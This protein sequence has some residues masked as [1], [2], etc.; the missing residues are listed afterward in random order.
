MRTEEYKKYMELISEN[1]LDEA[2]DF[3]RDIMAKFIYK[4]YPLT[5]KTAR[6]KVDKRILNTLRNNEIWCSKLE[7]FNDPYEGIGLYFEE[8]KDTERRLADILR[9]ACFTEN[10]ATNISMWAY[11]ANCHKGF[12]VK[13][14]VLNNEKLY[15]VN[16]IEH[17]ES[18]KEIWNDALRKTMRGESSVKEQLLI[19]EKYLI[20]HVS[21]GNE[22]E[23]RIII[24]TEEKDQYGRTVKCEELGLKPVKMYTGINCSNEAKKILNTISLQLG[25]GQIAECCVSDN[26]FV[27]LK[28]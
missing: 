16:Y 12:C 13:Y 6:G 21:W 20:K 8:N 15:D 18:Q 1:K 7:C 9:V 25:C 10:A 11:Y 2:T 27:L 5:S 17:R 24:D 22:K 19:Y 4:F 14:E 23:Y 28:E 3:R 26:E